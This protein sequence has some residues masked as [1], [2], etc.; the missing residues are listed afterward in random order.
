VR[1]NYKGASGYYLVLVPVPYAEGSVCERP[2]AI[3][4]KS[5][6]RRKNILHSTAFFFPS[7]E[8]IVQANS[9][10]FN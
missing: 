3:A 4:E 5:Y 7:R 8:A 2:A 10:T 6:R 9:A 1:Y